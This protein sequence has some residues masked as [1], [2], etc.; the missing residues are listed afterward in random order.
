MSGLT[1]TIQ[2][3][4]WLFG[5][6]IILIGTIAQAQ[7]PAAE[8]EA[9][10]EALRQAAPQTSGNGLYSDWQVLPSNIPRW[11]SACIERELTP[12]EFDANPAL[13]QEIVTCVIA[14]VWQEEYANSPEEI[15]A[16]RRV[17]AWWMTGDPARYNQRE[18]AVYTER[19]LN[20]Y[21]QLL[22]ASSPSTPTNQPLSPTSAYDRY[23][24][25]GYT[26][27]DQGDYEQALLHFRRALDERPGDSYAQQ[28]IQ[29]VEGYSTR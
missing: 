24:Q 29:N 26:A 16:V 17:A 15:I 25:A 27:T 10:V 20:L 1:R 18:T 2:R 19:V 21:Q 5:L 8:V 14:D 22:A 7:E 28:A 23:M 11:S 3:L 4:E 6:M 13:A 12:A 9:L